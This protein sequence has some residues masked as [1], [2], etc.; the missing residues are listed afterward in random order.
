MKTHKIEGDGL[1][2]SLHKIGIS[3]KDV[4]HAGKNIG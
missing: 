1:F 2:K 3:R 4:K